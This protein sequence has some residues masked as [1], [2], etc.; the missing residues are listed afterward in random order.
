[1]VLCVTGC[2]ALYADMGHFGANPTR[3]SWFGLALPGLLVNYF[4]QGALTLADP[5]TVA[6]PF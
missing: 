5:R 6:D 1:M 3:I 2:E 4:G